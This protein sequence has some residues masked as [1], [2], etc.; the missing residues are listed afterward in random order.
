MIIFMDRGRCNVD[1]TVYAR[2]A[3]SCFQNPLDTTRPCLVKI[4]DDGDDDW[5]SI[6]LLAEG[7]T[8]RFN[9]TDCNVDGIELEGWEFLVDFDPSLVQRGAADRWRELAVQQPF[10]NSRALRA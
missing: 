3:A 8:L 10:E 9:L 2:S 4:I 1:R 7:K 5:L 6:V